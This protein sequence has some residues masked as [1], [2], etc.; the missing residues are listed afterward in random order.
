MAERSATGQG[1]AAVKAEG[2]WTVRRLLAWM[3][4]FLGEKGVDS[5]R[6]IA[7]ILLSHVLKVERLKLYMEPD[8][9]LD[10][11]ELAELRALVMRA[12]EVVA[13]GDARGVLTPEVLSAAYGAPMEFASAWI[14]ARL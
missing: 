1:S 2:P 8:R 11:I 12:G 5:P 13:E 9:E 7:E 10:P 14:A 3:Q 6:H 4:S